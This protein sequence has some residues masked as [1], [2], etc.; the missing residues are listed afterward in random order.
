MGW[1]QKKYIRLDSGTSCSTAPISP[2]DPFYILGWLML[3]IR[4]GRM[5]WAH[6]CTFHNPTHNQDAQSSVLHVISAM[7]YPY[8]LALVQSAK[9][10][11][12]DGALAFFSIYPSF[13]PSLI[14]LTFHLT[15]FLTSLSNSF[16]LTSPSCFAPLFLLT[17][18]L[19]LSIIHPHYLSLSTS[20]LSLCAPASFLTL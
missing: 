6:T 3:A 5:R 2:L 19:F 4:I 17:L 15:S 11:Q 20:P 18:Y 9:Q 16:P 8:I 7:A 13:F 14:L 1:G 12:G 10:K